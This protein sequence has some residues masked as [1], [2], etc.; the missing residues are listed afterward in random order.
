MNGRDVFLCDSIR[1][2]IGRY[3]GGLSSVRTDDL[4]TLPLRELLKRNKDINPSAI[5]DVILGCATPRAGHALEQHGGD[6]SAKR[7]CQIFGV[8]SREFRAWRSRPIS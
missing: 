5:D 1:T 6:V 2:P 7:L 4:A 3:G 8:T